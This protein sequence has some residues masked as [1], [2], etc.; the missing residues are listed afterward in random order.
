MLQSKAGQRL[1]R[2]FPEIVDALAALP[3]T[4]F[5]LDGE[6]VIFVGKQL[7]FDRLLMRIHPAA[8]RIQKLSSETPATYSCF[9]LLVDAHGKLLATEP[10]MER[11]GQLQ[12][13]FTHAGRAGEG[14]VRISP[15]SGDYEQAEKWMRNLSKLGLDG[16]VAKRLDE[17]YH[18]G[19][20]TGMVKIKRI[21]TADVVVGGFRYAEK[22]GGI[23]SLLLGLYDD[24]GDLDH[25]GFTSSFNAAQRQELKHR[26]EPLISPPGF[27]GR[28]PGGPSRWSTKRSTEWQPLKPRLVAEVQFDHFSGGRFRHGAKFLR[29]RPEKK[30]QACT[31]DQL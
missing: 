2:Y 10:L 24:K 3:Q 19:E 1:D 13:F 20:R 30:P 28:A 27:T 15:A 7:S 22:G 12:D 26:L 4:R 21:R 18:S 6:I 23:A 17:P 25:V 5:V 9:D 31:F 11:R 16:I 8:S 14:R 29:W